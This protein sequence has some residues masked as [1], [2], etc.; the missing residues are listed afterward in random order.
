ME[1][2]NT[3]VFHKY[4]YDA[5]KELPTDNQLELYNGIFEYM[6]NFVEP[7]YEGINKTVFTLIKPQL[8]AN[9]KKYQ[10][11]IKE[12]STVQKK[13]EAVTE[14]KQND[15]TVSSTVQENGS[16]VDSAVPIVDDAKTDK[17]NY[18]EF[19]DNYNQNTGN[20]TKIQALTDNRKK[21]IKRIVEKY[22]IESVN[23][24]FKKIC[25]SDF[26]QGRVVQDGK[27][28]NWK[29]D[30]DWVF[31]ESNFIKI[32][33]GKFDNLEGGKKFVAELRG[34][35]FETASSFEEDKGDDN[36]GNP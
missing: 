26:L 3:A 33:E 21:T 5:I 16:T 18:K 20:I 30:F 8:D 2:R 25:E 36:N 1:S 19:K 31:K 27:Y 6:F 29:A 23:Q 9:I 32:M 35:S 22:T 24:V 34:S 4:I 11:G 14:V 7:K 28:K 15:S 13:E 10:N 12:K 17:F